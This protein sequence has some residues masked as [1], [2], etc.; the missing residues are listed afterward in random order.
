MSTTATT[1]LNGLPVG[2]ESMR[3]NTLAAP[4]SCIVNPSVKT[5]EID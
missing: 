4:S 2:S 1:E 5:L 3:S